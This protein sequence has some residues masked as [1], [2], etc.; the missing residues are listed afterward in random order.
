MTATKRA[1]SS[2]LFKRAALYLRVSTNEQTTENQR[3]ELA[4][5]AEQRGWQV[6]QV[7]EDAGISGAKGR[8]KRPGL[9]ALL[10]GATAGKFDVLM[11]WAIDRLGRSLL[12]LLTT[13]NELHELG[14]GLYLHQQAIDSTTAAGKAMLQM[15]GAFAEFER[16]MIVE[17]INAGIA[18]AKS[19]GTKSGRKIGRPELP[20]GTAAAIRTYRARGSS[21]RGIA[22]ELKVSATTVQKVLGAAAWSARTTDARRDS[23]NKLKQ[24]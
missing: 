13:M 10:K 5:V 7:L 17:R 6:V 21:I 18:R 14:V 3:L 9:D 8:D 16:S 15:C 4:R 20:E 2:V 12:Q 23:V 22:R 11:V 24:A 19:T 1:I